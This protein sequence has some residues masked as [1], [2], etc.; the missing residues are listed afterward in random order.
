MQK[1]RYRPSC[2]RATAQSA[3]ARFACFVS[4][5]KSKLSFSLLDQLLACAAPLHDKKSH[6]VNRTNRSCNRSVP[7]NSKA[8]RSGTSRIS[9]GGSIR[10]AGHAPPHRS[11][12]WSP[13]TYRS[14]PP[15]RTDKKPALTHLC[16]IFRLARRLSARTP[17]ISPRNI[18]CTLASRLDT[19]W[20]R[21]AA[22]R[23]SLRLY[24]PRCPTHSNSRRSR[25]LAS[26]H[27]H[28]P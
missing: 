11:T 13:Y 22:L 4:T 28:R 15:R 10:A 20:I 24:S 5:A 2:I 21:T 18:A 9:S 14:A 6:H 3:V 26:R 7:A 25:A 8:F 12:T 17:A 1:N 16:T 23:S 19:P 27:A